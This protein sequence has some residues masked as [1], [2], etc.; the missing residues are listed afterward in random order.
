MPYIREAR[1]W[2]RGVTALDFLGDGMALEARHSHQNVS[3]ARHHTNNSS[4]P[5]TIQRHAVPDE[6]GRRRR[7]LH[8]LQELM[9][10]TMRSGVPGDKCRG[11]LWHDA[12]QSGEASRICGAHVA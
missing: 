12:E 5:M 8:H 3:S 4:S 1:A 7:C 11:V 9:P 10:A 2:R 6:M